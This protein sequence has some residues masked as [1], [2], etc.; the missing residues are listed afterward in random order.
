MAVPAQRLPRYFWLQ[1]TAQ[2]ASQF[3]NMVQWIALPVWVASITGSAIDAGITFA[4][5]V[6]P[7]VV[8][9]PWAGYLAD[10]FDRT[11]LIVYC[12]LSSSLGVAVLIVGVRMHWLI[13]VYAALATTKIFNSVSMPAGQAIIKAKI[14]REQ[15]GHAMSWYQIAA[16]GMLAVGSAVGVALSSAFG[17][18][19]VLYINLLSFLVSGTLSSFIGSCKPTGGLSGTGV[20]RRRRLFTASS[21]TGRW[22]GRPSPK[23]CTF[24]CPAER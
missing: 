12:E 10:R 15:L 8:L 20:P 19:V 24:C 14:P 1:W 9:A 6:L 22:L 17:I 23:S 5:E 11:R 3:G 16:G 21:R 13:V 4:V 18:E 2:M 7:V